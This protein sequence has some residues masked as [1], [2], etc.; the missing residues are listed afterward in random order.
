MPI[1]FCHSSKN[2]WQSDLKMRIRL[3][4]LIRN[5]P[6]VN[7]LMAT[8]HKFL[9]KGYWKVFYLKIYKLQP[10]QISSKIDVSVKDINGF[11]I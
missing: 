3:N 4:E 11:F 2:I 9:S 1:I 5:R 8:V 7:Y 6:V 10:T